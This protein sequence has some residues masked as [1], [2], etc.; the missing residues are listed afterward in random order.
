MNLKTSCRYNA[1]L[2]P[3]GFSLQLIQAP[4]GAYVIWHFFVI[5]S[6]LS[7]GVTTFFFLIG[8]RI[9]LKQ[10]SKRIKHALKEKYYNGV[11][12]SARLV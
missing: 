5:S 10:I 1:K 8:K 6:L 7:L 4:G 9:L 2:K 11:L 12:F 3:E